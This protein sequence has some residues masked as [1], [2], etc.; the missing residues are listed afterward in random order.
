[1]TLHLRDRETAPDTMSTYV[2]IAYTSSG[3]SSRSH[4]QPCPRGICTELL[5]AMA[6]VRDGGA[7]SWD[8]CDAEADSHSSVVCTDL[9]P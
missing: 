9:L 4:V 1:M 5:A 6:A 7:S 2:H 8:C 3:L